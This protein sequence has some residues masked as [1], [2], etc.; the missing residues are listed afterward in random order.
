MEVPKFKD[1]LT[2]EKASQKLRILVISDEPE[3]SELFHTAK[4]IKEEGPKLGHKTYVVLIDGA[5]IK[6]EDGIKTIHNID[7]EKGFE[8]N[9]ENTI[10]IVRGSVTRKDA[11]LDL[12]SQLE[13]AGVACIN[14]RTTVNICADKYRTYLRLADYGLE[15]PKTVLVPNKDGVDAAVENLG[16]GFPMIMKTLRGSKGVGVIFVESER[17]LDSIVQLIYKESDDAELLIQQYIKIPFDVRVLVLGGK[18]LASM[19]R[20]VIKKDFRSNF[21]QGSKVT[22]FKLTELE[23]EDCI[24]AAKA[25]NGQYVAVDLIVSENREKQ[26]PK[27]IEVNSSPGTE[28]IESATKRNLIKEVIQHFEDPNNR[29]KVP[30]EVGHREV[31]T[32]KPFGEIEAKFDTGNSA[33]AVIHTDKMKVNGKKITWTLLGKTITSDIIEKIT[34]GVGGM[35][36]YDEE[37]YVIKLDV[38]FLGTN[39]KDVEFTLD[40]RDERSLILFNRGFMKRA[41]VM[42][43]PARRYVVTTK[44]SLED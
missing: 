22:E 25:V 16:T 12:L 27:I 28:G 11:W 9:D 10:A 43:N 24:L 33:K 20:E 8:I 36:D 18:V 14:S 26:R 21:S 44:Y 38:E 37:R 2:E 7:D 30:T 41:N 32:I 4:R 35:R 31:V 13:K 40:D 23:I 19:K 15:Q 34:V 6:N 17:S 42:V 29:F 3:N 1:F 39:Y 5:Y